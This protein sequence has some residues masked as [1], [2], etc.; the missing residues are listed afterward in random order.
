MPLVRWGA[1]EAGAQ[2]RHG[3]GTAQTNQQMSVGEQN[4][5]SFLVEVGQDV[6]DGGDALFHHHPVILG[7]TEPLQDPLGILQFL[8]FS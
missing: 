2:V 6:I 4:D 5:R 1:G 3:T 7:C 8:M